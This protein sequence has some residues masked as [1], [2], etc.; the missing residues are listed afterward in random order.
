MLQLLLAAPLVSRAQQS[1]QARRIGVLMLPSQGSDSRTAAFVAG[2]RDAGYAEGRTL[3]IEWRYADGDTARLFPLAQELVALKVELI[4]AIQ[5]QAV[6][7]AQRATSSIPIV[8]CATGDPVGAGFAKSLARPDRNIT[9][10]ASFTADFAPKQLEVLKSALPSASLIAVLA[11]PT[12]KPSAAM[13]RSIE[14]AAKK[15]RLRTLR[16]E[17]R[18]AEELERAIAAPRKQGAHALIVLP[19]GY[20]VQARKLIADTALQHRLPTLG[21]TRELADAGALMTYGASLRDNFYRA[22]SYVDRILKGAKPAD[23]P[24]ERPTKIELVVNLNTAKQ[25]GVTIPQALLLRT[26]AIIE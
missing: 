17:A 5:T 24:I 10:V 1:G 8:F 22:A 7:A 12:N 4:V 9:G 13:R 3:W 21:W 11:N 19:D 16:L 15:L 14:A 18:N 23:L 20:F 6:E 2:L 25:L 26:D